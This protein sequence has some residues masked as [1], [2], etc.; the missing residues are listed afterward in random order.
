MKY[1]E[2]E[3]RKDYKNVDPGLWRKSTD[4]EVNTWNL[5]DGAEMHPVITSDGGR[6]QKILKKAS[7]PETV[8]ITGT[9]T[10]TENADGST[11]YTFTGGSYTASWFRQINK[12]QYED[13]GNMQGASDVIKRLVK[14][15]PVD[16]KKPKNPTKVNYGIRGKY[17]GSQVL[18]P[19]SNGYFL[20]LV[21]VYDCTTWEQYYEYPEYD[22][23]GY[24][25]S[26]G[27]SGNGG[28]VTVTPS[29]PEEAAD[30]LYD[31]Y[32]HAT[33]SAESETKT[34]LAQSTVTPVQNF[35][36]DGMD[37]LGEIYEI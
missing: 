33:G 31:Y 1:R 9:P 27:S 26:S 6:T 34:V 13:N 5:P 28:T 4:D 3:G 21:D 12:A 25:P 23:V 18:T 32:T 19:N 24:S 10:V 2:T 35:A 30:Q 22:Y 8:S 16:G 7:E 17:V 20:P 14:V 29:K 11:T 15:K 36:F 37:D